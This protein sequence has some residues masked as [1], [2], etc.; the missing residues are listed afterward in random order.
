MTNELMQK[1]LLAQLRAKKQAEIAVVGVSMN[2]T[3]VENDRILIAPAED[4]Q[5]GEILV[6]SYKQGELLVH[7]LLDKKDGR[8][9]CKGDNAFRLEDV[10]KEQIFGKVL[11]ATREGKRLPLYTDDQELL[12]LSMQVHEAF[13]QSRYQIENTKSTEIY[14]RYQMTILRKEESEM[15]YKKNDIMDYIQSDES[16][17]AVFD[18]DSGNTHFLDETGIDILQCLNEPCDLDALLLKLCELYDTKP[19]EIKNDV[20]EFLDDLV[21]KKVILKNIVC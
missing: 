20:I 14:K 19:S 5:I 13:V 21:E 6:F 8:Y 2:P 11:S 18:P 15:I 4:Y 17:L 16:T 7:R 3:L 12:S 10:V 9:F 1:L